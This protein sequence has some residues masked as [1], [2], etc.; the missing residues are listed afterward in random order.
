MAQLVL[1]YCRE[2]KDFVGRLALTLKERGIDVWY[3]NDLLPGEDFSKVI[4]EH[5]IT[6]AA[7]LVVWSDSACKSKWVK[8]EASRANDYDKLLQAVCERCELPLPFNSMNY[9]DLSSWKGDSEAAEISK[10]V[11][12]VQAEIQ[13]RQEDEP[14]SVASARA[15]KDFPEIAKI[16]NEEARVQVIKFI[17]QGD[18]SDVYLGRD[19][20]RMVAIKA[21]R[22]GELMDADTKELSKELGLASYLQHPTFLRINE[23]IFRDDRSFIVTD[24]F[25]GDTLARKLKNATTFLID[26]VVGILH[27]LSTAIAEAHAR[28][29]KY[30]R[31]TPS[32]ILVRTSKIYDQEVA[33]IAPI[34]LKYFSDFCRMAEELRWEDDAGPYTAPELWS[35]DGA[36]SEDDEDSLR[37]MHQQANQ[38]AL[39]MVAWTMLQGRI[40]IELPQHANAYVKI[41]AFL[42]ASTGFSERVLKSPWHTRARA[43]ANIVSRMVSADPK[44]R[45]EDMKQVDFLIGALAGDHAAH[46]F[47]DIVKDTYNRL[48]EGR[49]AFYQRFYDN[50]F[51]RDPQVQTKFSPDMA[52]QHQMLH[53]GLGQLLNF[54][55]KQAEPTTLS[56]FVTLHARFGL[57][58]EDFVQFGEAL[59]DTFAAEL[60]GDPN[61]HRT[62]AAFEII[63]WP[64]IDYLIRQCVAQPPSQSDAA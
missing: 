38:F 26:D 4:E 58:A 25:E 55:Q 28:G 13:R 22:R 10:I 59:I 36:A 9:T 6:S 40:P 42:A 46:D 12:A 8:A 50:F 41:S 56:Q 16:L 43:L 14:I 15:A 48:C 29:L 45:W 35:G 30:V 62:M 32:D 3:D 39:G 34:N 7:V 23:A 64:G 1:S 2:S 31:I 53:F 44:G 54:S 11:G 52:R 47:R 17:A 24:F 19:G 21:L 33:R 61:C 27:Q 5:I 49:P 63:I 60:A 51:R 37:V 57:T 20:T 18:S